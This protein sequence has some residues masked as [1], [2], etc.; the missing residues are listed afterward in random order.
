MQYLLVLYFILLS[1]VLYSFSSIFLE[2]DYKHCHLHRALRK[3]WRLTSLYFIDLRFLKN[4]FP[5]AVDSSIKM[6]KI[7]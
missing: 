4:L 1:S 3:H 6:N 2:A 5:S 7:I